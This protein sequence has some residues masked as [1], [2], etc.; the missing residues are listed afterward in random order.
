MIVETATEE[1]LERLMQAKQ[2][3][4]QGYQFTKIENKFPRIT[5]FGVLSTLTNVD[6]VEEMYSLNDFL[7]SRY[8]KE[9]FQTRVR[10]VRGR[11]NP[12]IPDTKNLVLEIQPDVRGLMMAEGYKLCLEWNRVRVVDLLDATRCFHS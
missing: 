9:Q 8:T 5:I 3:R 4:D 12:K 1:G 10:I 11:G 7:S 2:L 6:L